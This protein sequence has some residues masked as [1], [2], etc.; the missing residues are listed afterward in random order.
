MM[1]QFKSILLIIFSL[2][3]F[4]AYSQNTEVSMADKFYADGK[5]YIVIGVLSI[6]FIGIGFYLFT[7]DRKIKKLEDSLK[8]KE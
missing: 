3:S 8:D 5:I 6:I 2:L 1:K 7:I 4:A